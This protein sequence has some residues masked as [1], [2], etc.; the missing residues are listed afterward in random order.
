MSLRFLLCAAAI[1]A[2]SS[3]SATYS[4]SLD[5]DGCWDGKLSAN[6][7]CLQIKSHSWSG[8]KISVVYENKC[9]QRIF[10]RACH[11]QEQG[12]NG[13]ADCGF[14]AVRGSGTAV[15]Y[16]YHATGDVEYRA[17]GST[18]RSNDWTCVAQR[19]LVNNVRKVR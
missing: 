16:T 19:D 13:K 8:D 4:S 1:V 11:S 10:A 6:V 3:A 12:D 9:P 17:V 7:P 15:Y 2:S 5:S 18:K 14:F